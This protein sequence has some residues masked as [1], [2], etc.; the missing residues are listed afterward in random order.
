MKESLPFYRDV[1]GLKVKNEWP[2]YAIFDLPG[3]L[4]FAIGLGGKRGRKEGAPANFFA[5][6]DLD[7]TYEELKEKG[8][9]FIEPP[10]EQYWGGYA[11]LIPDPD[12]NLIYLAQYD[13]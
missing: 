10:K 3:T 12:E 8:V 2:H 9:N 6:D 7:A 4:G 13:E 11:A 5:V 1:L